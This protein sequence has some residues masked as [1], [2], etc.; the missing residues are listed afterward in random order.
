MSTLERD[1]FLTEKEKKFDPQLKKQII[2]YIFRETSFLDKK[3]TTSIF[4]L[5]LEKIR[6][7]FIPKKLRFEDIGAIFSEFMLQWQKFKEYYRK[8]VKMQCCFLNTRLRSREE[9]LQIRLI[10]LK[11]YLEMMH[12]FADIFNLERALTNAETLLKILT[13]MNYWP[14]LS[15]QLALIVFIT[16][17]RSLAVQQGNKKCLVQNNIILLCNSS[18]YAF[19]Q[20]RNKLNINKSKL[21]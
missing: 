4:E 5:L 7:A 2:N 18:A 19:H 1:I 17:L 8:N 15:T 13:Q 20:A 10:L 14:T 11:E 9:L 21:S 12:D 3:I 16:D 6:N